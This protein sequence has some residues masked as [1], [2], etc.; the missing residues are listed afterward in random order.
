VGL[1]TLEVSIAGLSEI[2][3]KLEADNVNLN[4]MVVTAFGI[5]RE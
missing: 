2:N 3:V 4:E 1:K 5:E